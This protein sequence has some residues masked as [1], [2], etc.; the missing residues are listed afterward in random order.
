MYTNTTTNASNKL[1][2]R[3][4]SVDLLRSHTS[5][6][7]SI[8][9]ELF[10]RWCL[11]GKCSERDDGLPA[12][13]LAIRDGYLNFYANGRS[14]AK[15]DAKR[16]LSLKVH[17][18]YCGEV[19]RSDYVS[20]PLTAKDPEAVVNDWMRCAH[21]HA[22][23]AGMDEKRFVENL[24]AANTNVID[25]EMG[26]PWDEGLRWIAKNDKSKPAP[27]IDLVTVEMRGDVPF[28][29]FWEAK[30][31]TNGAL[32]SNWR[33]EGD[34]GPKVASQ[35]MK[36]KVWLDLPGRSGQVSSAYRDAAKILLELAEEA[37][38]IVEKDHLWRKLA[39]CDPGV[40]KLPGVVVSFYDPAGKTEDYC[41]RLASFDPHRARLVT[42]DVP[43]LWE[44]AARVPPIRV[45]EIYERGASH[46]LSYEG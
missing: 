39:E 25:L 11:P 26:L 9:G 10:S 46:S 20:R 36:Y 32:R 45:V 37:G 12:L 1:F 16:S 5:D 27:R 28:I 41:R 2:R 17:K 4:I 18:A 13:R 22:N 23:G 6:P 8:I 29:V 30:M 31:S 3:Q 44:N 42:A 43:P 35:I 38:K 33:R 14:I 7:Q 15:I 40:E 21:G 19:S 34:E 24:V